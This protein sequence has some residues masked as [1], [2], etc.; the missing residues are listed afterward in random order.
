MNNLQD[1]ILNQYKHQHPNHT[2]KDISNLTGI[3][4]T[5][6]FRIFNGYEMKL[7]EFE[8]FQNILIDKKKVS[9]FERLIQD[10]MTNLSE[11]KLKDI[12]SELESLLKMQKITNIYQKQ[13]LLSC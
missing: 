9:Y 3:Q 12:S 13:E 4:N 1:K 7:S 8:I 11:F 2:L 6:V 10:C 5:R